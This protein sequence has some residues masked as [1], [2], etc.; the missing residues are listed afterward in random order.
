LN[1]EKELADC[2]MVVE[3]QSK[4]E[5]KAIGSEGESS[6]LN[7][8]VNN[9]AFREEVRLMAIEDYNKNCK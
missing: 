6:G 5:Y 2:P 4:G 8:L 7:K 9:V 3:K 1:I